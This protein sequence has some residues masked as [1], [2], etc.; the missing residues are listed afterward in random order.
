MTRI[1]VNPSRDLAPQLAPAVAAI[2][3]GEVVAF[4]TDTLY[5]LAADPCSERAVEKLFAIK[6]RDR[7]HTVALI[8]STLAQ[9]ERLAVFGPTA[10]RLAGQFWPGPLTLV[11]PATA[12][13]TSLVRSATGLIGV[14]VPDHPVACALAEACG[15]P[16]TATSANRSGEPPSAEPDVVAAQLP[17][18]PVMVDSGST[19][20]GPPSTV[21]EAAGGD[22]RL[23]REGA[24]PWSRVL[25]FLGTPS[26]SA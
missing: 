20:G 12:Q 13:V 10:R 22:T 19:P 21:V 4:P 6:G 16:L 23:L 18:V 14:R 5:G 9:A 8:A 3:R 15:H 2:R 26:R 11:V 24:I 1:H 7:Q 17:E 25:E